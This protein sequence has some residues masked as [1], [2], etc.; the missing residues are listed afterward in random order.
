MQRTWNR[1]QDD[2]IIVNITM[3]VQEI[4]AHYYNSFWHTVGIIWIQ[5]LSILILFCYV[6][7]KMKTYIFSKQIIKTWKIIPWKKVY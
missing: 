6:L 7:D 2:I 5:Y 4:T 1:H 3:H